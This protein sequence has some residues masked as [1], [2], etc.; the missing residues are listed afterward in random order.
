MTIQTKHYRVI[1]LPVRTPVTFT[2]KWRAQDG[3]LPPV[4]RNDSIKGG[5]L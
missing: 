3:Y 1:K 4:Y 2:N 5:K